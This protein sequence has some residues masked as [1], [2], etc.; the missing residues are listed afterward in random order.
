MRLFVITLIS[1]FL[2][3][4]PPLIDR[5]KA[6]YIF[7]QEKGIDL[8]FSIPSKYFNKIG[9]GEL[10]KIIFNKSKSISS[11]EKTNSTDSSNF[12]ELALYTSQYPSAAET[13]Q[14]SSYGIINIC[15]S[16]IPPNENDSLGF[17]IA[18][19]PM[20]QFLN[21]LSLE[22]IKR[23]ETVE[24]LSFP[25][26]NE[27]VKRIKAN[28]V[29]QKGFTGKGIK[30]AVLDS[31]LDTNFV[32]IELPSVIQKKDYSNY[33]T[34]EDDV[35]NKVTGHGTHVTGSLL[36]KGILSENNIANGEGLYKGVAPN[37][38]LIFLKI[39][40]D[41]NAGANTSAIV[42]ALKAAVNI[43]HADIITM[44]Y[45]NW[46]IYHDGSNIKDQTI[47][48]CYSQG[49][50]VFI[51]AGNY[52][53]SK[54]H[55][56]GSVG[57]NDSS[58]LIQI[59][60]Q[61]AS[62]NSTSLTFNL[63]WYDYGE[64]KNLSLKY[65][66]ELGEELT[67]IYH[68]TTTKSIR[69]TKSNLSQSLF[70]VPSGNSTYYLRVINGSSSLQQFHLYEH[71]NDGK[72]VFVN[73]DPNYTISSPSTADH[74]FTVGSYVSRTKWI[75]Y[76]GSINSNSQI[77]GNIY[78][79][80]GR[81]PRIDGYQKPD[82][83]APGS[84][85][86]SLRDKDVYTIPNIFF[87]DNDGNISGEHD[88]IIMEGTSMSSAFCA[89]AAALYLE[90]D[91]KASPEE[92]YNALRN[93]AL[94]DEYT[95]NVPSGIYGFGK[96]DVYTAMFSDPVPVELISFTAIL[97]NNFIELKWVTATEVNNYGFD[98]ERKVENTKYELGRNSKWELIRFMQGHGNSNSSKN[99]Y[100]LDSS[101]LINGIYTYRL[102]QI[103]SYG[104]FKYSNEVNLVVNFS[105]K[106]EL[107]QNYP[108]PFNSTTNFK[109]QIA[110]FGL[111]TL[112]IY[113]V[114]G[115]I[116]VTIVNEEKYAGSYVIEFNAS[117]LSSGIYFYQL[118]AGNFRDT[119]KFILMK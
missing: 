17:F 85:I 80:S 49:V 107:M 87:I 2:F 68:W 93:N 119:K 118:S 92:I 102:K 63:V 91:P 35:A 11:L 9:S 25:Q 114:L 29:W 57:E 46:D 45:G 37:S 71:Y 66:N 52:A 60:V 65:Y 58:D 117:K 69:G 98:V 74:A 113:D 21:V 30:I 41:I 116:V 8:E 50:P 86:I 28:M 12:L 14:L 61:D 67:N 101:L 90:K 31:G 4:L 88:Y 82:I 38:D 13:S 47:D 54:R 112:K 6:G 110:D 105:P 109:F 22:F 24:E 1:I 104:T 34:L 95:G 77:I 33:P 7:P 73:D 5:D 89:G 79:Y 27:A 42:E 103:D 96:L 44:S 19:I 108:N 106:Y 39:G 18:K 26:N 48:W 99:Y 111:A 115:N 43:Y 16:W 97:K 55:F 78:S 51:P 36:S 62:P 76:D 100:F 94:T 3:F 53:A 40:N 84:S 75:S 64:D 23:V 72:V 81:G 56:S 32:G 15:E 59:G 70:Q 10:L 83:V 20:N